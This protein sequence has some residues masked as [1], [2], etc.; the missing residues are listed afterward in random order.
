MADWTQFRP[1]DFDRTQLGKRP[2]APGLFGESQARQMPGQGDLLD[3][4]TAEDDTPGDDM[5]C[6]E[7]F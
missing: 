3:D 4:T 6:Q 1:A 2:A 5:P 7:L